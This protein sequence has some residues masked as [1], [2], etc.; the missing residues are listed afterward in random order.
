M[1]PVEIFAA[2]LESEM[3]WVWEKFLQFFAVFGLVRFVADPPRE[4]I[5]NRSLIILDEARRRGIEIEAIKIGGNFKNEFRYRLEGKPWRYFEA[6]P[7]A[8]EKRGVTD[9][10]YQ[11]KKLMQSQGIPVPE[12]E[13]FVSARLAVEYAREL[14]FPVVVK[15]ATGSLGYHST[16][17]IQTEA[18]LR[19]A[20][21]IAQIFR[22]DFILEKHIF[23]ENF[24]AT[25][26][27]RKHVF[28]CGKDRSN[29]VG[30]GRQTISQLIDEKNSDPRKGE[31]G[32]K[33]VT[34]HRIPKSDPILLANLQKQGLNFD[35][36]P[37]NGRKVYFFDDFVPG[38][39]I[40]FI[41]I[42]DQVHAE[43]AELFLKAARALKT[44]LVGFDLIA[45]DMH[46]PH[47][48]QPFAFLEGNSIPY[49]D[50]HQFPSHG[51]PDDIASA[52]WDVVM[53]N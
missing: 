43:N 18:E 5:L 28:V 35:S 26:V 9:H 30:D 49:I 39:G 36:V 13:M 8:D 53:E 1:R 38:S 14:G 6:N 34:L 15:P 42:T 10:K 16:Y 3:D 17:Q 29:V 50:L 44:D 41:N 40:D 2:A 12:G 32:P 21:N 25:V 46:R 19:R 37:E 31:Y 11:F 22:P 47:H 33:N 45:V 52:V 4:Q 48:A 24:R 7:L 51:Q 27:G 20:I 23:G